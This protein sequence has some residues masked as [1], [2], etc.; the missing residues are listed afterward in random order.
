MFC[1]VDGSE[2]QY[3]IKLDHIKRVSSKSLEL[4]NLH[5][6]EKNMK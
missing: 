4:V 6:I 1:T 3:E 5:A 2:E